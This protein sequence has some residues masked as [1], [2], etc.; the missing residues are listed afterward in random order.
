MD[1]APDGSQAIVIT[2]NAGYLFARRGGESWQ[3]AF[4]R[5]PT[6]L[7]MPRMRAMEAV[8]FAPDGQTIYASSE[9]WPAPI[10]RI[11]PPAREPAPSPPASPA[12]P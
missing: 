3:K 12:P 2:Y 6:R 7:R 4:A 11:D 10:Y 5:T 1:I 9:G 8:A